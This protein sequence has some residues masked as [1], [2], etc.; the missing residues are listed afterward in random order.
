MYYKPKQII[1][2]IIIKTK[3]EIIH[4]FDPFYWHRR[5]W[6]SLNF[7]KKR[8]NRIMQIYDITAYTRKRKFRKS[9]D[10]NLANMWVKNLKKEIINLQVNKVWNSDF[11]HLY[12]KEKELYLATILDDYSKQVVWYKLWFKHTK[13]LIIA[14]VKDAINKTNIKPEIL[15]SDQWSEYRSYDYFDLLKINNIQAS[16]SKKSSPWENPEQESFYWKF[17][18]EL[19][20]LNRFKTLEE[21]IEHIHLKI[22]YYNNFR[23]HTK[24]KMSPVQ[25]AK[26]SAKSV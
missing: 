12:Y 6:Y 9:A 20:N 17:K 19:W 18:F 2:D 24:L 26:K 16:M 15:H 25:F 13:E 10:K 23:I 3:I 11:T 14:T 5:I 22:Y 21:A 8:I 1:K 7:N 4:I